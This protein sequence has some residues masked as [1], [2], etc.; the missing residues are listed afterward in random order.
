MN[1][2]SRTLSTG[3]VLATSTTPEVVAAPGA[4]GLFGVVLGAA[5]VPRAVGAGTTAGGLELQP[6]G[7]Q[8]AIQRSSNGYR[9]VIGFLLFPGYP[10]NAQMS[11]AV[12][13]SKAGEKSPQVVVRKG[14]LPN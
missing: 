11:A 10:K 4:A 3:S 1:S 7:K 12:R 5:E 14:V 2:S 9:R 8:N 13:K 6:T